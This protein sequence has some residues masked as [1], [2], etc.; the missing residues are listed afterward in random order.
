LAH[1]FHVPFRA[2]SP[3]RL[4]V[5]LVALA[6]YTVQRG[7]AAVFNSTTAASQQQAF[8]TSSL[9]TNIAAQTP[10]VF[11]GTTTQTFSMQ[12]SFS[13][14]AVLRA[15]TQTSII[16]GV[17]TS[18]ILSTAAYIDDTAR[19]WVIRAPAHGFQ[20]ELVFTTLRTEPDADFVTVYDGASGTLSPLLR[21]SGFPGTLPNV[22][23]SSQC[24]TVLFASD[25]SG[26]GLQGFA[27]DFSVIK[28]VNE[29][30]TVGCT[31]ACYA[32]NVRYKW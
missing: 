22:T 18:I 28:I 15:V 25:G 2:F 9:A 3:G 26:S 4:A 13:T 32:A 7:D 6:V 1:P 16:L 17:A 12:F 27:A 5:P 19:L 30:G 31:E 10:L 29:T 11:L 8:I 23:S 14:G 24:M 21:V 20:I